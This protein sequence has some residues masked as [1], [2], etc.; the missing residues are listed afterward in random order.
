[1][2]HRGLQSLT[3]ADDEIPD[4][5]ADER[6]QIRGDNFVHVA[7]ADNK[8]IAIWNGNSSYGI[9]ILRGNRR[10]LE[11]TKMEENHD[12]WCSDEF[13]E[14]LAEDSRCR[15]SRL[16]EEDAKAFDDAQIVPSVLVSKSNPA[17]V[18]FLDEMGRRKSIRSLCFPLLLLS[19]SPQN[20]DTSQH[21]RERESKP[22]SIGYFSESRRDI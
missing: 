4:L 3:L 18:T 8:S 20:E 19:E 17:I 9:S 12:F 7:V 1:V 6:G 15:L 14:E 22:G 13:A 5:F 10:G 11:R 16:V 21:T 2:S